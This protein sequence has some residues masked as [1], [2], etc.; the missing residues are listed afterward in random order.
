MAAL[1]LPLGPERGEQRQAEFRLPPA[2][3]AGFTTVRELLEPIGSR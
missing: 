3:Q 1:E 2:S